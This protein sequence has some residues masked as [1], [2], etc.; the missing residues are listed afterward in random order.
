[1]ARPWCASTCSALDHSRVASQSRACLFPIHA[2][3]RKCFSK[4]LDGSSHWTSHDAFDVSPRIDAVTDLFRTGNGQCSVFRPW[5]GE[6]LLSSPL[7]PCPVLT[8]TTTAA[9]GWASMSHTGPTEGTLK[10]YPS[11]RLST[12][13]VL[14]RP[15]FRPR[16]TDRSLPGYLDA[17]NW[18]PDLESTAFPGSVPGN[19]QEMDDTTHPHLRLD[20][21]LIP[22]PKVRPGDHVFWS[23]DT[24]HAVESV[25][26]GS[27][28]SSVIYVP[29]VPLSAQK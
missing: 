21:A 7:R 25:H 13:Y 11:L 24:I 4:L 28:D 19:G 5:Q 16:S 12:A 8:L 1:V 14:L 18:V 2:G 17:A 6:A 15:F 3:F 20:R 9:P 10:V 26:N 27:Q 23:G 29:A 22:V